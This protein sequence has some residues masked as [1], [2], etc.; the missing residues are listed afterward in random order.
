VNDEAEPL[1]FEGESDV[2]G[3]VTNGGLYGIEIPVSIA[4]CSRA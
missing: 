4:Q 2:Q 3:I 1:T